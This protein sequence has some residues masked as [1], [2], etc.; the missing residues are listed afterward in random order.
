M[1]YSSDDKQF[2][3]LNESKVVELE[4]TLT[5]QDCPE[6]DLGCILDLEP[7]YF[8]LNKANIRP[9]A[10]IELNKDL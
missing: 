1:F 8:D 4:M 5:S 2:E 6:D 7:I 3:I 10:E 9:D